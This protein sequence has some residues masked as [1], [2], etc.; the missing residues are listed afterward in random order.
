MKRQFWA[1]LRQMMASI[2]KRQLQLL[3]GKLWDIMINFVDVKNNIL[4]LTAIGL[5]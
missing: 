1:K 2:S 3:S 4:H 5:H